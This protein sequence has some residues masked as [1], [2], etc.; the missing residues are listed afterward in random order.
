VSECHT[1][2]KQN[3]RD[4]LLLKLPNHYATEY[5]FVAVEE[6]DAKGLVELPG[7]SRTRAG[8]AWGT[9]LR[10]LGYDCEREGRTSSP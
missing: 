7:N 8:A 2:L 4:L 5:G 6:L 3:R 1:D 10:M 9:F